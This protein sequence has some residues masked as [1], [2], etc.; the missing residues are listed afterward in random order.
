MKI[1]IMTFWWAEEN[2]G[3]VLQCYALQKYL[4]D[5]G[6]DAY[7]IRYDPKN[8]F[9]KM[10]YIKRILKIFNPILLIEYFY[11]NWRDHKISNE[12]I[13]YPRFFSKFRNEYIQQSEKIYYS[14]NDLVN[15]PPIADVY[16]TGSD[17]VWNIFNVSPIRVKDRIDA[18]FL[19]FGGSHIKRIAYAASF[20]TD[21]LSG[22]MMSIYKPLLSNFD[23][24]SVREESGVN[25]CD[26]CGIKNAEWVPDPTMLLSAETYRLLY[27]DKLID[28]PKRPYCFIYLI[29][30]QI[31][32]SLRKINKWIRSNNLD[33]IYISGSFK[34]DTYKK[35]Y[36][37][38]PDWIYLIDNADYVITNSYHSAVFSLIFEKKFA[39]IPLKG[40]SKET[41]SRFFSLFE[42]FQ[43]NSR[44]VNRD[45][46]IIKEDINWKDIRIKFTQLRTEVFDKMKYLI[47]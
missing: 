13:K 36:A 32:V 46:D 6:Y 10:P 1:G 37:T 20:G 8:D 15:N 29:G 41:N 43:I 22:S 3:Q 24:I 11:S 9:I 33:I 5:M 47:G 2:Y 7:L 14:Y 4:R 16:I 12:R 39:I 19:N 21:S 31:P 30:G 38:I 23:Y 17:Q 18:Y 28:K 35:I 27:D 25:I 42:Q 45:I 40:K 34:Y 44:I 26:N